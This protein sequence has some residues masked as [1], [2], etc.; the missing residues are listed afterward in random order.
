MNK[1]RKR[2]E[3]GQ[4]KESYIFIVYIIFNI[5]WWWIVSIF[6]LLKIKNDRFICFVKKKGSMSCKKD[7][8][9]KQNGHF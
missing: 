5:T 9:Y 6:R 4:G 8:G 1:K 7:I 2:K 3:T